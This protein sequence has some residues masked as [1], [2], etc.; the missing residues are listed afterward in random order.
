MIQSTT[1]RM[2]LHS[3][4]ENSAWWW[5][6][7]GTMPSSNIRTCLRHVCLELLCDFSKKQ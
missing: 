5:W 1:K 6:G 3:P 7:W 4:Q 2:K